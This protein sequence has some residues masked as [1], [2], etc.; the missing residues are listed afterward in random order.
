MKGVQLFDCTTVG[1][2]LTQVGEIYFE[3][4]DGKIFKREFKDDFWVKI[5]SPKSF[6]AAK[7][8][9]T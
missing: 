3:S 1:I 6:R 2:T 7:C 4:R 8:I 9:S 5:I